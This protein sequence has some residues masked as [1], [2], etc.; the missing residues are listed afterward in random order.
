M[1]SPLL[2]AL[3][4]GVGMAGVLGA[5]ALGARHRPSPP[6]S[7]PQA[8]ATEV[9]PARAAAPAPGAVDA[10]PSQSIDQLLADGSTDAWGNIASLYPRSDEA[11]K[12]KVLQ[13]IAGFSELHRVIGYVLA[14]VGEDPTPPADDPLVDEASNMLKGRFGKFE[15][16]EYGRQTMVMQKTDKRRWLLAN[17]LIRHAKPLPDSD[18]AELKGSLSAKLIDVHSGV[19]DGYVRSGLVDGVRALGARDAALIL[20]KAGQVRDDELAIVAEEQA[21]AGKVLA[22]ANAL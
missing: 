17:A 4:V 10:P 1:K 18:F 19:R 11:T 7:S 3:A 20:E 8:G 2:L 13:R 16:F 5:V 14:T 6:S 15:N 22:E 12:R 21:A 9:A